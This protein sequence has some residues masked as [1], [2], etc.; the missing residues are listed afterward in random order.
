[1][2]CGSC[3]KDFKNLSTHILQHGKRENTNCYK[4]YLEGV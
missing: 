2:I 4:F 1:M 3:N